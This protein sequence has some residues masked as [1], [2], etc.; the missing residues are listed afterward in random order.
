MDINLLRRITSQFGPSGREFA[1]AQTIREC[2]A[3]CV[4]ETWYDVMGNL[5]ALKR[6]ISGKRIMLDAHMDQ[7]GLIVTGID[8]AGFLSVA[9]IGGVNPALAVGRSITFGNGSRGVVYSHAFKSKGSSLGETDLF[10]DVGAACRD[11]VE[12][13]APVGEMAL[14]DSDFFRMGSRI[15]SRTLDNRLSCA[16]L[17]EAMQGMH[18]PHDVYAIFS[19]QEEVGDRGAAAAADAIRPDL[20]IC[21]DLTLTGDQPQADKYN[22]RLGNGAAV[23]VMD[24]MTIVPGRVVDFITSAAK[25]KGIPYQLEVLPRAGSNTGAIQRVGSGIQTGAISVPGRYVHSPVE[26]VDERDADSCIELIKACCERE[27]LP[28]AMP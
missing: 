24:A 18:S 25:E 8:D 17:V 3:P 9:C 2:I 21:V 16:V 5:I 27:V 28:S 26:T 20:C 11:E 13:L 22:V 4:D 14:F 6:G 7:I 15:V 10:V 1:A 19:V 23:K 12:A